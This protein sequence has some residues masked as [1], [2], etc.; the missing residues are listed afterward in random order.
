[1]EAYAC[2]S[3]L[4]PLTLHSRRLDPDRRTA[5]LSGESPIL[6]HP[7]MRVSPCQSQILSLQDYSTLTLGQAWQGESRASSLFVEHLLSEPGL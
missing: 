4:N 7:G 1:M 5:V 2:H 6:V 3:N